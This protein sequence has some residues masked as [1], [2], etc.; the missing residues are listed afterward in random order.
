MSR[1]G[2]LIRSQRVKYNMT[3]KQLAKKCGVSESFVLEVEGGRR[4]PGDVIATRLLKA[5]GMTDSALSGLDPQSA[6]NAPEV[7]TPAAPKVTRL[8]PKSAAPAPEEVSD[9]WKDALSGVVKRVNV[10][11][12]AGRVAGKQMV[13]LD[14]DGKIFGA[15]ADTVFYY[16][17]PDDAMRAFRLRRGDKLLCAPN[18][19]VISG[20]VMVL[21][22]GGP[23][24]C[25]PGEKNRRQQ[26]GT[27]L[28]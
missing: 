25:P 28:V 13:A 23:Y 24:D 15:K 20:S 8:V 14:E 5:M 4:I 22:L 17:V 6:V 12:E 27:K 21:R 26:G 10:Y 11:N 16:D 19:T 1:I 18:K 7:P 9:T 2:D 3:P